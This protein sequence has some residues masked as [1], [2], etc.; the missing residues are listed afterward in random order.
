LGRN[1]SV[2]DFLIFFFGSILPPSIQVWLHNG[3]EETVT[4]SD[5]IQNLVKSPTN[6]DL[7][8]DAN[9]FL[10]LSFGLA[11]NPTKAEYI[12]IAKYIG[13][14]LVGSI[15]VKSQTF[16]KYPIGTTGSNIFSRSTSK[17]E[18]IAFALSCEP[19]PSVSNL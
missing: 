11:K 7:Q 15:L 3:P 10:G 18:A 4:G 2:S 12:S 1:D 13:M 19:W 6:T 8:E 14:I 5:E 9:I 17:A 16:S